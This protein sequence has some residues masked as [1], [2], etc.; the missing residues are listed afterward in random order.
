MTQLADLFPGYDSRFVE[1]GVGKIFVRT[2]GNGPPVLLL[3]G[4]PQTNVM[5]HRVAP[6]PA[7]QHSLVLAD[8]PGYGQSDAPEPAPDHSPYTKRAMAKA[9]VEVMDKLGHRKFGAVGHDRG[10]RVAYRLALDHPERVS[11]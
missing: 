7:R 8:L 11:H 4:Y 10:G 9:M 1:T 2:G 6:A 5:W 3:H